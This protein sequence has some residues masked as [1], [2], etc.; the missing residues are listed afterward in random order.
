VQIN[1]A[2]GHPL[3]GIS[4]SWTVASG[5]GSLSSATSVTDENGYAEVGWT[6][7]TISGAGTVTATANSTLTATFSSTASPGSVAAL[8]KIGG[9]GQTVAAGAVTSP[10]SIRAVDVYGNAVSGVPITWVDANG[11]VMSANAEVT[12]ANGLAQITL[13]TD[14]TTET[15][16][17]SAIANNIAPVTF[18]ATSTAADSTG[19]TGN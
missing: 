13:Q 1:D 10:F 14:A 6:L 9:D 8:V 12:D 17:I 15:Y 18:T 4:V 11:G 3:S 5:G 16:V 19:T 7:G 2:N